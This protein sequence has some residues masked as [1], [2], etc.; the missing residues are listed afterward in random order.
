MSSTISKPLAESGSGSVGFSYAQAAKGR[1][2]SQTAQPSE[3]TSGTN[4]PSKSSRATSDTISGVVNGVNNAD[5]D[6]N[7]S[8]P[9]DGSSTTGKLL[10]TLTKA[11]QTSSA[12]ATFESSP[13]S[14]S[15]GSS[16]TSTLAKEEESQ[17]LPPHLA[18][19]T[20]QRGTRLPS[21]TDQF[22]EGAERKK[23]KKNKKDKAADKEVEKEKEEMKPAEILVAAPPPAVNIWQQRKE[24][25]AA[26]VKPAVESS[27]TPSAE[28]V[29]NGNDI[30]VP[31]RLAE[32]K[33]KPKPST[34]DEVNGPTSSVQSG[35][36]E[37]IASNKGQK[38]GSEGSQRAKEELNPRRSAPR[39]A[40]L[41][42]K[43]EKA[44]SNQ[45]PPPVED[46]ISW[47]TP[48][49]ALEEEKRKAQERT[50]K[51]EKDDNTTTKQPR[52]KEK[53]VTVP[54]I[55]TVTFNTP[56]PARGGRARGGARGGREGGRGGHAASGSISGDK[57]A[58]TSSSNTTTNDGRE[59]GRDSG[60]SSRAASLPPNASKRSAGDAFV[61]NREQRKPSTSTLIDKSKTES[62]GLGTKSE[63]GTVAQF[64][65]PSGAG[66]N[67]PLSQQ[68]VA[69]G[70][71]GTNADKPEQVNGALSDNHGLSKPQ[72]SVN[73][74]V[75]TNA[76][77]AEQSKDSNGHGQ[78]RERGEGRPDRGRGSYRGTRG[79]HNNFSNGQQ[80]VQHAFTNG[81]V[82]PPNGF[83]VR[84]NSGPYSPTL[85][86]QQYSNAYPPAPSRGGRGGPRSQ[87]IPSNN[88]YG[89]FPPAL[90][91]GV[92]PMAP[93]QTAAVYDYTGQNMSAMPYNPYVD[94]YSVL[95]MV[96]M[97]LEYY[98]SIDNLCKDVFL[99]RHMDSQGFVFLSI[100]SG[101]K[102][103]QSLTK[104]LELLRFACQESEVIESVTGEDGVDRLRRQKGWEKWV[105]PMEDREEPARNAG[106]ERFYRQQSY[107]RGQAMPMSS[108]MP[109]PGY[110]A[111]SPP[112]FSP[113]DTDSGFRPYMTAPPMG[114]QNGFLN[115]DQSHQGESPL[116]AAVPD[117]APGPSP[118]NADAYADVE[119]TFTDAE[120]DNLNLVYTLKRSD[121]APPK[122]PYHSASSRTFS[123]GSIDG[124]SLS[125]ELL[126]SDKSASQ[127][128]TNG[129]A[130]ATDSSP[131]SLRRSR[132]PFA[133]LSPTKTH[134]G[135][136]PPVM[137]VKGQ[138]G[139]APMSDSDTNEP[140][141]VVRAR[142]LRN[143]PTLIASRE[144]DADM[145]LLY[146]FWSHF[147]VRN[148]NPRMYEEFRTCALEDL[149]E[150]Q[151]AF[152]LTNL[153]AYYDEVLNSRRRTIPE[154]L[155]RHYVELVKREDSSRE[156]PGLAKLR[157]AWRNGALDLKSR[158]RIDNLIDAKL[159]EE[160]E[161]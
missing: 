150:K 74:K 28:S 88:L 41:G 96:T 4:G 106:P 43:D 97:Q 124:R 121:D 120:V 132:S 25:Q 110:L 16:S 161:R 22:S 27:P 94:Q 147:L 7:T 42:D 159:R 116:S 73:R 160:L 118:I 136:A 45:L 62:S 130:P 31:G 126:E 10:R 2:T 39:G 53:W 3:P 89:R 6:P 61:P 134:F 54:Y 30:P 86:Q 99:R 23:A 60:T 58:P 18:D 93:L 72:A 135:S 145:R 143:R 123:N 83:S 20:W 103:I 19:A 82:Q 12:P 36:K 117:F 115:G 40:R 105:M 71:A 68:Q 66:Q 87:S 149:S 34:A 138:K 1:T 11:P 129:G 8:S 52:S 119:V 67:E 144:I 64:R 91:T 35:I 75:E 152:G 78:S 92:Q 140:Y 76:R 156:R 38:K 84:S 90:P 17:T 26:K 37:P 102:R 141:S 21:A 127:S 154:L 98:F 50:E 55:P 32:P 49:T 48:E 131:D 9:E 5:V 57:T 51:D 44:S 113:N 108:R 112:T 139:Q 101:F 104:D 137:W 151:L 24:A 114:L 70:S 63:T 29:S 33:R 158:K 46:A 107:Q 15:F 95:A 142:A 80:H 47:P 65:R 13:P 59:R 125:E 100:V 56:L 79:G 81:H 155:A 14:P 148:F 122:A 109:A 69:G 85:Q 157:A 77:A 111:A 153:I 146:E 133:P 128:S